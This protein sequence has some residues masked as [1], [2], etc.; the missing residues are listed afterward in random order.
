MN[1]FYV[2]GIGASAGGL[3]AIQTLFDHIPADTGMSFV[4]VQHLSPNFKSMMDE[5]LAKHTQMPILLAT[6][7]IEILP[8]HVYLNPKEKNIKIKNGRIEH[9]NKDANHAINLPIDIFFHSLGNDLEHMSVGII[10][11][12]TGTDGSRGISTIKESGGI[13]I[14]QDPSSAQFDGM[15]VT[16][17]NTRFADFVLTPEK[18][19]EELVRI[20]SRLPMQVKIT[21]DDELTTDDYYNKIIAVISQYSHIDFAVYK[22]NTILRRIEKRI[23]IKQLTNIDDYYQLIKSDLVEQKTLFEECLIGV[24][25]FFRDPEAFQTIENVVLPEI[26][27]KDPAKAIARFWVVGCS[28]GEEAYSLAIL[29][30]EYIVKNQLV[31][32]YKIFATDAD[33]RALQVASNGVYPVNLVTDI[34]KER[35]EKYFLKNG[36]HFEVIKKIRE[37]IVFSVHNILN[38]PPFI[39]IDLISCRNMLIYINNKSQKKIINTFQF[40]LNYNGFLFLGNSEN[41]ADSKDR[42]EVIDTKWRI[43][44]NI[45][46]TKAYPTQLSENKV[47]S[48]NIKHPDY[49]DYSFGR[50]KKSIP[51]NLFN[52]N[53][54][55]LFGPSCIYVDKDLNVLFLNGDMNGILSYGR[56]LLK[57]NLEEIVPDK[58]L[59][60]LMRN[61]LRKAREEK[62]MV[63]FENFLINHPA[64]P[65]NI[66]IRFLSTRLESSTDDVFVIILEKTSILPDENIIIKYQPSDELTKKQIEELERDLRKSRQ[67]TQNVIEELETSNEELQASNEELQASNEELQSTNE[68]LQSVNEEL[69]TINSE[70]QLKNKEL[71]DLNNDISNILNSTSLALLF[72]NKSLEIRFFTPE[73]KR[74][75]S[76]KDSDIGRPIS[77]FASNFINFTGKELLN[78]IVRVLETFAPISRELESEENRIYHKKIMPYTT[79]EKSV[80]GVVITFLDITEIR[81]KDKVIVESRNRLEMALNLGKLAWWDWDY[82]T[83]EVQFSDAKALMLGYQPHE[84][85]NKVYS[86]TQMIHPDDY[87]NA[88]K[89]MRDHLENKKPVYEVEYRIKRK[90]NTYAWFYDKGGIVEKDNDGKPKRITGIVIDVTKSKEI[91]LAINKLY[92]AFLQAPTLN[93]ITDI[94]GLV[95][96]VNDNQCKIAGYQPHELIGHKTSIF[97]SGK[98]PDTFYRQLW[99]TIKSGQVWNGEI[100]NKTKDGTIYWERATISPVKNERGAVVSFIKIAQD[101]TSTIEVKEKMLNEKHKAEEADSM[102]SVFLANMSHEIR[103]PMNAIVGFGQ[104]LAD[105]QLTEEERKNYINIINSQGEYLLTLINDIID[106]SKIEMGAIEL[107]NE[108]CD[109][110]FLMD[111]L[112]KFFLLNRSNNVDIKV[113]FGNFGFE[114]DIYTDSTR[115]RQILTNLIYN[116]VKFTEKGYVEFGVEL[117]DSSELIFFVKDTG[118]GIKRSDVDK[119]FDRFYQVDTKNKEK[120]KKG[121]GLGLAISKTLVELMGGRIWVDTEEFVGSTFSFTIPYRPVKSQV[122]LPKIMPEQYDS[123]FVDHKFLIVEDIESNYLFLKYALEPTKAEIIWAK[124]GQEAIQNIKNDDQFSLILMDISMPVLDGYNATSKIRQINKEIPIIAITAFAM[125][126]DNQKALDAGCN[127]Y[128]TKPLRIDLLVNNINKHINRMLS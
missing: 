16:A 73:I 11:S 72:L 95:E 28:S 19:G 76:L 7:G 121:T 78:D 88:M 125:E 70:L 53:I 51:E 5:L 126:G 124:N 96:Y 37:R 90:D 27:K 21:S 68:E 43:Y 127:D 115:L 103:T 114:T 30:D 10:L 1:D 87:E 44:Q 35:L 101:I 15:P 31:V 109:I 39:R 46:E 65:Q 4:I 100:A 54:A 12:G 93:V 128:L 32:D 47:V 108:I 105:S 116:A 34:S 85:D 75:F 41:I 3:D 49:Y 13:I 123:I 98:H 2:V 69:Y 80:E 89:A 67:E 48:Y 79:R 83:G 6:E 119:I 106:I 23:N 20:S 110:R 29:I 118:I 63:V 122:Q 55:E 74:I 24:T 26:F 18:I 58:Q 94:N 111:D 52:K 92:D 17:I 57:Q 25:A 66:H 38:D 61:G 22:P 45:S 42:F 91:S 86:F 36:N 8:N 14:V 99:D 113:T 84:L 59:L 120:I 107:R 77:G 112:H 117:K 60:A 81:Q 97:R 33:S 82:M 104:L 62:K 40:S 56:G 102:K 9:Y 50:F 64:Q 71:F